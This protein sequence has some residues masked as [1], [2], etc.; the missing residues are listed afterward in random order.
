MH[1][2][3]SA[4]VLAVTLPACGSSVVPGEAASDTGV[5]TGATETGADV[6]AVETGLC[7]R[8]SDRLQITATGRQTLGCSLG[9]RDGGGVP[10]PLTGQIV[11]VDATSFDLDTCPP[12]A[13]C[14]PLITTFT[15]N[16]PGL[17]LRTGMRAKSYVEVVYTE[18]W[19]FTCSTSIVVRSVDAWTGVK[20]PVDVGGRLYLAGGDGADPTLP[21]AIEK[22]RQHCLPEGTPTC[23]GSAAPDHYAYRFGGVATVGMGETRTFGVAGQ[24]F[25]AR[26]LMAF[27]L[28]ECDAYWN[29]AFWLTSEK[30]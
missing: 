28:G 15:V 5:E 3:F 22:V 1:P 30:P 14:V 19:F 18:S 11:R 26:N 24:S 21:F 2:R 29:Y 7:A 27:Y 13:D 23:G 10:G 20:N 17:D 16:A 12:T 25:V 8:T 4:L 9:R 6:P